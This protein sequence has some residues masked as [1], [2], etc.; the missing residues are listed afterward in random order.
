MDGDVKALAALQ[1]EL[2][3]ALEVE[4]P[5]GGYTPHVTLAR[6]K[7]LSAAALQD[8]ASKPF[9]VREVTL[10]ESTRGEYRVHRTFVLPPK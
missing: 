3:N 5:H 10:F 1:A 6:G 2:M 9:D 7:H 8:F 4:D